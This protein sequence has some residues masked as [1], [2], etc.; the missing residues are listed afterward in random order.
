[1][2]RPAFRGC[3][4]DRRIVAV[5]CS[6]PWQHR[7][8]GPGRIWVTD[9]GG[10]CNAFSVYGDFGSFMRSVELPD[11]DPDRRCDPARARTPTG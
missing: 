1:M 7:R 4:R 11:V 6:P 10:S 3:S 5:A 2:N 8:P 9:G